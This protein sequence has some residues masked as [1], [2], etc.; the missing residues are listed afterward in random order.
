[1][2][3]EQRLEA[4][5]QF[6]EVNINIGEKA[7]DSIK[8]AMLVMKQLPPS[9]VPNTFVMEQRIISDLDDLQ[10]IIHLLKQKKSKV[11]EDI[12]SIRAPEIAYL[13]REGRIGTDL[14][15]TEVFWRN[16]EKLK[17][18]TS[19][20]SSIDNTI[21]YLTSLDSN[22]NKYLFLL[23]DRVNYNK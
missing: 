15:N 6:F 12:M 23:R 4:L 17:P 10:W 21:A 16:E 22:L 1:M 2:E 5:K 11:S 7:F 3:I 20:E 8:D 9:D 14:I 18:L 13:V 19:K